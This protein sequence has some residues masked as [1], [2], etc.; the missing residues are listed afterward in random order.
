MLAGQTS[1]AFVPTK[2]SGI[3]AV[4]A[5]KVTYYKTTYN[6]KQ[7]AIKDKSFMQSENTMQ[8]MSIHL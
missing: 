1:H 2:Q 5:A 8:D 3:T 7:I 6:G 4:A